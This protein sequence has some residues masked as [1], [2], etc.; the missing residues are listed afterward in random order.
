MGVTVDAPESVDVQR[1]RAAARRVAIVST[2]ECTRD[3]YCVCR[4]ARVERDSRDGRFPAVELEDGV[5]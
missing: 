4:C 5:T 3:A 1:K 2:A